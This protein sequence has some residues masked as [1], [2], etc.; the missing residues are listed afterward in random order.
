MEFIR[1]T[2]LVHLKIRCWS[3]EKKA[4]RDSDITVGTDGKLP[5]EKLLDL[6]RKK[7]FPPHALTPFD[8][9]RKAAERACL[10][11]GTR[12]MGGYAV[13]DE[14]IDELIIKLD[15]IKEK[16]DTEIAGFL[17]D[18]DRNKEAWISENKDFAHIIRDQVPDRKSVERSFEFS[19]KLF[20]LQPLE[21][22]EPDE[23][24][25]ANQVLHEIGK[26]CKE[27]SDNLLKRKTAI[28]G[29]TLK[30]QLEP[31][32]KKLDTLSFGNGRLLKM[33]GEFRVLRNSIPDERID[34][35]HSMFG[36][37]VTFLSMCGDSDKLE[38]IIDG[39]YSVTQMITSV[40][41]TKSVGSITAPDKVSF[42][43]V[44]GASLSASGAYF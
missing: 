38:L 8:R 42:N 20:K 43:P 25:V 21:G 40:P 31:I 13:P 24:E 44:T 36:K 17:S 39:Q 16:F 19:H 15:A 29:K 6:G 28:G 4:S 30:K 32:V 33:L 14:S 27:M 26:V 37:T 12:F 35:E 5:P 23:N 7:I 41:T 18:F 1:G 34:K 11:N 2:T 3:G 10:E 9:E 22:H